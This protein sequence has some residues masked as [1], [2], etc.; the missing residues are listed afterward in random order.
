MAT[1]QWFDVDEFWTLAFTLPVNVAGTDVHVYVWPMYGDKTDK[2][3]IGS[4]PGDVEGAE[5]SID[6]HVDVDPGV[7]HY[8]AETPAGEK[9]YPE[10]GTGIIY[11]TE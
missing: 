6:T 11:V 8:V 9:V 10:V 2:T 1:D 5:L 7:Y 4:V 3:S